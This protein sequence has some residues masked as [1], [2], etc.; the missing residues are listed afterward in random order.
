MTWTPQEQAARAAAVA[1]CAAPEKSTVAELI[2]HLRPLGLCSPAAQWLSPRATWTLAQ[3]YRAIARLDWLIWLYAV[4]G[5]PLGAYAHAVDSAI[6]E[7]GEL[8]QAGE[9]EA[10]AWRRSGDGRAAASLLAR[11]IGLAKGDR[12]E[13]RAVLRAGRRLK[14]HVEAYLDGGTQCRPSL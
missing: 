7:L 6:R 9:L 11:R 3:A 4:L 13:L 1:L 2:P 12:S 8:D 10:D 14:T 5:V